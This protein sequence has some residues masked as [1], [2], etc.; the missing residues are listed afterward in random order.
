LTLG[1][2]NPTELKKSWWIR[3]YSSLYNIKFQ[4]YDWL[5]VPLLCNLFKITN[6]DDFVTDLFETNFSFIKD[7]FLNNPLLKEKIPIIESIIETYERK[8]WV[9]C[10]CTLF[11]LL[12]FLTRKY[13]NT[14]KLEK[15]ITVVSSVFK[16]AGYNQKEIYDL[17][18][19][20][21]SDYLSYL[22]LAKKITSKEMEAKFKQNDD[23]KPKLGL[24]GIA[25][26]SF[27]SFGKV[28]YDYY[29]QDNKDKSSLNRHSIMH[30]ANDEFYTKVNAVKL[31]TYLYLMLEL[32]P[33]LKIVF[34][35][36]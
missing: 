6:I 1:E 10:I 31:I 35:E 25:L 9:A 21:I 4:Y 7:K 33:V 3:M 15:D 19:S 34:N 11:P 27:L 28:Y 20:A 2:A 26:S 30:G 8:N 29:R 13:F 14:T 36:E 12:D 17:K 5:Y 16:K 22:L 32:E 24:I 18:P 23:K